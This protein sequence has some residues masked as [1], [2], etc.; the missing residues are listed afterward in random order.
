MH[1]LTLI[2]K[3]NCHAKI[4]HSLKIQLN[5]I[6]QINCSGFALVLSQ[7]LPTRKPGKRRPQNNL[8]IHICFIRGNPIIEIQTGK[9]G[10]IINRPLHC[11]L[12]RR[13]GVAK[14]VSF[15]PFVSQLGAHNLFP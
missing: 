11:I 7:I 8:Q 15:T 2:P 6:D 4:I 5:G 10:L 13:I 12:L 14:K 9:K 3:I 1:E